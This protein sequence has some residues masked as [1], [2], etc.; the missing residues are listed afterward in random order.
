MTHTRAI[1]PTELISV[2]RTA[3][4]AGLGDYSQLAFM[5]WHELRDFEIFPGSRLGDPRL[6]V[7]AYWMPGGISQRES[8]RTLDLSEI[9][10]TGAR[11][12][13]IRRALLAVW[14][15][16]LTLTGVRQSKPNSWLRNARIVLKIASWQEM[17]RPT[18]DGVVFGHLT[19]GDVVTGLLPDTASNE[20]TR[21]DVRAIFRFLIEAG[22]RGM[23]KDW[24]RIYAAGGRV[25]ATGDVWREN[26]PLVRVKKTEERTWQPFSD[27]F[28]TELIGR[29]LWFQQ[30]L[31]DPLLRCWSNLRAITL[32]ESE[33]H[34]R[35]T[36]HPSVIARRN[37]FLR[38]FEWH[39]CNGKPIKQLPFLLKTRDAIDDPRQDWRPAEAKTV[40]R[41]I[42]TLQ[43][44][45]VCTIAF[46][47]GARSSEI[48]DA[49]DVGSTSS[50]RGRLIAR[51]FKLVDD[52]RGQSRDW[53]LHPAA[54]RAYDVQCRLSREV[55]PKDAHHLWVL[56][57]GRRAGTPLHNLT[58]A[59]VA[60]VEHI[61]LT[62]LT[63]RDRAHAHRWRQTVAR[64]IALSVVGAPQVLLDLF[65]H[66]DVEMTLR[67]M[68]S[69][70]SIV[71]EA[72]RVARETAFVLAEEAVEDTRNGSSS[73]AA[74][75][76]LRRGLAH[77]AMRR[78]EDVFA[79]GSLRETAEIMTFNGR[80]WELVRPGVI[81]T[82]SVASFGP[83]TKSR[84]AP[85][86]GS[87]HT[88]CGHR[89]ELA[90][91]K[92]QCEQALNAL[93]IELAGATGDRM[94]AANLEGQVLAQMKRW[95]DVRKRIVEQSAVAKRI[96]EERKRAR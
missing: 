35:T 28:V 40:G 6:V 38:A 36:H 82:K 89:L 19:L 16:K 37:E 61:G 54:Q 91:A 20:R 26:K 63:G 83:C 53:P 85:D 10:G 21:Q 74:S 13:N 69:N 25:A 45:N 76:T 47:T 31:A 66:R 96:W 75:G 30:H 67:Y 5:R 70:P 23:I 22:Q 17:N 86:P 1:E 48:A 87:C 52:L 93:L 88:D 7:P 78:G 64:L 60:A 80:H 14:L 65:G 72:T 8:A 43:A 32:D 18:Q 56:T 92:H 39:D 94:L 3:T 68:L 33:R 24:P 11:E 81:C 4:C 59:I 34:N 79:S 95:D 50:P 27:E 42:R 44:L 55:R 9:A 57:A 62:D 41:L 2:W 84:G 58:E 73:G 71:E 77:I 90:R 51:T 15:P 12:E 49:D 46:C 29:A